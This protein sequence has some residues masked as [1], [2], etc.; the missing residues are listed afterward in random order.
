MSNDYS[1]NSKESI[2]ARALEKKPEDMADFHNEIAG[3][4]SGKMA[5]PLRTRTHK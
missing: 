3:H 1:Y 5:R 2:K 4:E